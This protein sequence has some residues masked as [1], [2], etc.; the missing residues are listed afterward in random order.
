MPKK[1]CKSLQVESKYLLL[2]NQLYSLLTLE[3]SLIMAIA[4]VHFLPRGRL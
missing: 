1:M 4:M 3:N 2:D